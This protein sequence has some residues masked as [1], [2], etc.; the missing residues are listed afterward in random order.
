MLIDEVM[1]RYPDSVRLGSTV[2]HAAELLSA[3]GAGMLPVLDA[4]DRFVGVL[5]ETDL[6]GAVLPDAAEIAAAGNTL[7]N[8]FEAFV[9]KGRDRADQPI[10]ALVVRAPVTIARGVEVAAAAV[11]L[12]ERDL[13]RIPVLEGRRVVGTVSR[14]DLC[15]AV[16]A[17]AASGPAATAPASAGAPAT[18]PATPTT[19]ETPA[20]AAADPA[21]PA[22][23][24]ASPAV[25]RAAAAR[26]AAA[27]AGARRPAGAPAQRRTPDAARTAVPA[28]ATPTAAPAA[29]AASTT[30]DAAARMAAVRARAAAARSAA[31]AGTSRG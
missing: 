4:E 29:A 14:T 17:H 20:P 25:A 23:A 28:A 24:A 15:R 5:T 26:A 11:V 31:S 8:A 21:A 18:T 10:D 19:P 27:R 16:L 1:T 12:L 22:P 6:L 13:R 30:S 2:R 9:A 7:D 3:S